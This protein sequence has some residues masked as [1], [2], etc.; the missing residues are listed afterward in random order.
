M[1]TAT[2]NRLPLNWVYIWLLWILLMLTIGVVTIHSIKIWIL[3]ILLF[4]HNLC[5]LYLIDTK[6]LPI[7]SYLTIDSWVIVLIRAR[8]IRIWISYIFFVL[9]I[10]QLINTKIFKMLQPALSSIIID[11]LEIIDFI[12]FWTI[13]ILLLS[14]Q[15][16]ILIWELPISSC[17]LLNAHEF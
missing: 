17:Y 3:Y 13:I 5:W 4:P 11:L 6:S 12:N 10:I 14:V 7:L 9:I 16:S 15:A 8:F 2:I 1:Y